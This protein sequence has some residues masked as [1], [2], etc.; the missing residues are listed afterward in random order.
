MFSDDANTSKA[1]YSNQTNS[2]MVLRECKT[3]IQPLLSHTMAVT[4]LLS[5]LQKMNIVF[6]LESMP[7]SLLTSSERLHACFL[8]SIIQAWCRCCILLDDRIKVVL[9]LWLILESTF[10]KHINMLG[11]F[12]AYRVSLVYTFLGKEMTKVY[13]TI[14]K[15]LYL[16][17]LL[18][19]LKSQ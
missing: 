7:I 19:C 4:R 12:D 14:S 3:P 15:S 1:P 11:L 13:P 6:S 16:W 2:P 10:Y 18:L 9:Q 8:L 17:F 5:L